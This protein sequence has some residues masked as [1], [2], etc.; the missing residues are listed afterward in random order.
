[1]RAPDLDPDLTKL[2]S[3]ILLELCWRKYSLK[4]I[5]TKQKDKKKIFQKYCI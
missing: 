3:K 5:F 4:S 2:L 1:L